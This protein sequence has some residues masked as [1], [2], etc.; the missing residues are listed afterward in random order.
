MCSGGL[1]VRNAIQFDGGS[2]MA[3]KCETCPMRLKAEK[4]PNGFLAKLWRWHTKWCPGWRAYQRQI[5][6]A[7]GKN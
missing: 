6:Q 2:V 1:D 3:A 5:E 7:K 4:N